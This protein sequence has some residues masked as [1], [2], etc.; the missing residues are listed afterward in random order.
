MNIDSLQKTSTKILD[1][2]RRYHYCYCGCLNFAHK[3]HLFFYN[4]SRSKPICV[5][6]I[7]LWT[8]IFY[9]KWSVDLIKFDQV[10]QLKRMSRITH[11]HYQRI[12]WSNHFDSNGLKTIIYGGLKIEKFNVKYCLVGRCVSRMNND[13][14][15]CFYCRT[16]GR[17]RKK[18]KNYMIPSYLALLPVQY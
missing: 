1:C 8:T 12:K 4:Q 17:R 16:I 14:K 15:N 6:P 5:L 11:F 7:H 2:D 13:Y 18:W 9:W 10:S 3:G